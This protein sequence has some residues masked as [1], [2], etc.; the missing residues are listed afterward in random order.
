MARRHPKTDEQ[1]VE[2]VP[3]FRPFFG[4]LPIPAAGICDQPCSVY[5][6]NNDWR[7]FFIA[8]MHAL[9]QPDVWDST[10]ADEIEAAR[11]EIRSLIAMSPCRCVP[12]GQGAAGQKGIDD[13]LGIQNEEIFDAGGLGALAPDA[14]DTS[15]SE[16][17]GDDEEEE[18]RRTVALCWAAHDYV[19]SVAK[20]GL[21]QAVEI[22]PAIVLASLAL[23]VIF[24]PIVGIGFGIVTRG[25]ILA[26]AEL[27]QGDATID[28]VACCLYD[29]LLGQS[30]T[31][32]N[33]ADGLDACPD[34]VGL[35]EMALAA[36]VRSSIG[37]KSSFMAFAKALGSFMGATQVSSD[38]DCA[39][40]ECT[41]DFEIDEGGWT[42]RLAQ[43]EYV[44]G[45]G[46]DN[47]PGGAF[48]HIINIEFINDVD[49]NAEFVR[50]TI[51]N[52]ELEDDIQ[53]H[54]FMRD[55][56]DVVIVS[57]ILTFTPGQTGKIV[58]LPIATDFRNLNVRIRTLAFPDDNIN[59][60]IKKVEV[61]TGDCVFPTQPV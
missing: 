10:D 35:D 38:C 6:I 27:L 46:W 15:Y 8:A 41:S 9:D 26:M 57:K 23:S 58:K 4:K 42:R 29:N 13:I 31:E 47:S 25:A 48:N 53:L 33:F 37:D 18:F 12:G 30:I 44:E 45:E 3:N 1:R 2:F 51:E 17:T 21:L 24:S 32:A 22:D 54:V 43:A 52:N 59:A 40:A 61:L 56:F 28:A 14:P 50:T 49:W 16:D 11:Q 55:E 19:S 34:L 39:P 36:L 7:K 20:K 60:L 5:K